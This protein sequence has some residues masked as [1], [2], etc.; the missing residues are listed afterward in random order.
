MKNA[1]QPTLIE[2][3]N[4]TFL[5]L[6]V[7]IGIGGVMFCAS[8]LFVETV[9]FGMNF[10]DDVSI[11]GFSIGNNTYSF[12]A[13]VFLLITALLVI[14]VRKTFD[15]KAY[16]GPADSIYAAHRTDNELDVRQGFGSTF[17]ALISAS[18]GASVGQY[19]PLV[20]FGATLGSMLRQ[21]TG[22]RFSTDIFIGCG[23]AAAISAGFNAPIVGVIFAHEAIL[24]HFSFKAITPI[25]IASMTAST[26][27]NVLLDPV[28]IFENS[29]TLGPITE[30]LP[31]ALILGPIFGIVSVAYMQSLRNTTRLAK[32]LNYS[33]STNLLIAAVFCGSIGI[34]IP[35]ILGLGTGAVSEMH[36]GNF[37]L[38]SLVVLFI[39]KMIATSACIGFGLFGGIFSPALFIGASAGAISGNLLSVFG[40]SGMVTVLSISGMAAVGA[41]VIGAPITGILIVLELTMSYEVTLF[42]TVAIVSSA[43]ISNLIFGHS[44][45]DLQ[46]LDRGIDI[47][48]GRGQLQLMEVRIQKVTTQDFLKL[49]EEETVK[50]TINKMI[51]ENFTEGYILDKENRFI[52][53]INLISILNE[54]KNVPIS[55][56]CD[57]KPLVIKHDAS[58]MQAIEAASTFVGE[59]IPVVNLKSREFMGVVSEADIFKGYLERQNQIRDLEA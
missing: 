2:L 5:T 15:I 23:V 54:G 41:A 8:T 22:N 47:S 7:G 50:T 33:P 24:R 48:R 6:M 9:K 3:L 43:F 58:L 4:T 16:K 28:H 14:M 37:V 13:L 56:Y 52:G 40:F 10:R 30:A 26:L 21:L 38:L 42:A 49:R 59:S 12:S 45:F 57:T 34:F 51:N 35:E 18:G 25:V 55:N 17:A 39:A 27:S 36:N 1:H 20:H 44:Y 32:S 53:K 29:F 11:L 31:I 46:L 19:G